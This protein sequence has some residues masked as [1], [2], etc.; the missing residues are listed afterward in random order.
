MTLF[1]VVHQEITIQLEAATFIITSYTH[2]HIY[3]NINTSI[4]YKPVP[5]I[6][7]NGYY[8]RDCVPMLLFRINGII[9]GNQ[10]G[11]Y[12]KLHLAGAKD[13]FDPALIQI[14][15]RVR[16]LTNKTFQYYFSHLISIVLT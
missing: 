2:T 3:L 1:Q 15:L 9:I 14:M 8:H 6:S 5:I 11:Y 16:Q 4:F 12:R 7:L 10:M 13:V